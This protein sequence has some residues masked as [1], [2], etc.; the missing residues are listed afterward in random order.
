MAL[1]MASMRWMGHDGKAEMSRSPYCVLVMVGVVRA[2]E[3]INVDA[4]L[5]N[6][7]FNLPAEIVTCSCVSVVFD[8]PTMRLCIDGASASGQASRV[9]ARGL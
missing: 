1:P 7:N 4:R 9:T 3:P 6:C 5:C 2:M 8:F